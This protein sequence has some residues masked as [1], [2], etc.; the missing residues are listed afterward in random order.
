MIRKQEQYLRP[1]T[2]FG[3]EHF[4]EYLT[5]AKERYS[6]EPQKKKEESSAKE[7]KRKDPTNELIFRYKLF[8]SE[9]P[10]NEDVRK[11]L[12]RLERDRAKSGGNTTEQTI[13]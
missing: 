4:D 3:S 5:L 7:E 2:L 11:E 9:H 1:S 6:P 8:L 10:D 12:E 13:S